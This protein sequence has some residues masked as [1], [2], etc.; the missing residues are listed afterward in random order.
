MSG[1]PAL[2]PDPL[3]ALYKNFK[4]QRKVLRVTPG[5]FKPARAPA[6]LAIPGCRRRSCPRSDPCRGTHTP[7]GSTARRTP[8]PS[9][10]LH[11]RST[12]SQWSSPHGTRHAPSSCWDTCST[13]MGGRKEEEKLSLKYQEHISHVE[14]HLLQ[15]EDKTPPLT[16]ETVDNASYNEET[17]KSAAFL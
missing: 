17:V 16:C 3:L 13:W 6:H 1:L 9:S 5:S 10:W 4:S 14:P 11:T 2:G 15:A 12:R 8:A 7:T